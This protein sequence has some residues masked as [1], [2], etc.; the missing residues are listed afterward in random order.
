M[1]FMTA[2]ASSFERTVGTRLPFLGRTNSRRVSSNEMLR[3]LRYRKRM[4]LMAWFCVDAEAWRST[5]RWV[6]NWLISVMPISLG[7]R[8][9]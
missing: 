7:C 4:A 2:L 3:R 9:L 6:M 8:L 5:T 1:A